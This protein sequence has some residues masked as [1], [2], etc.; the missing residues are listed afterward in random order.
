MEVLQGILLS[1]I[2]STAEREAAIEFA[3]A[4]ALRPKI[5]GETLQEISQDPEIEAAM[6]E[7]LENEKMIEGNAHVT[8]DTEGKRFNPATAYA[9]VSVCA[10]DFSIRYWRCD[11]GLMEIMGRFLT[12]QCDVFLQ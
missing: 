12:G 9:Q 7:I 10:A 1:I 11:D 6:F 3:K 4:A 2:T 5:V 8:P